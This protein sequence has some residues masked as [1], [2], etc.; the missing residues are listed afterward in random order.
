M[1]DYIVLGLIALAFIFGVIRGIVSQVMAILGI[2][3]AYFLA[4]EWGHKISEVLKSELGCSR[5]MAD[6]ASVLLVGAGIYILVR[7]TGYAI[8]K[9]LLK[10]IGEFKKLNRIGGGIFG[11]I[12]CV[13]FLAVVFFFVAL[14]PR[15]R[16]KGFAPKLLESRTY[17]LAA[18]YN[19]MVNQ[20][21]L[22][23][24]RGLRSLAQSP[25]QL[26]K[27]QKDPDFKKVMER[28]QLKDALTDKRFI[29]SLEDGDYEQLK[30]TENVEKLMKDDDLVKL[31]DRLQ[32][33]TPG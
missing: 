7:L 26:K 30:H 22:E 21:M 2:V 33:E 10:K 29:Q 32:K 25:T 24:M 3:L 18:E 11:A 5:F 23:R 19:P 27:L 14:V 17:R 28:H 6:K 16:V 20:S 13:A 31:I 9:L 1:V 15:D 8:E 12:K 4:P